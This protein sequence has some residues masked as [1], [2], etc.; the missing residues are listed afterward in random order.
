MSDSRNILEIESGIQLE[1]SIGLD[2]GHEGEGIED[3]SLVL[4]LASRHL[5]VLCAEW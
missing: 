2:I 4:D 1:H 5:V 3:G